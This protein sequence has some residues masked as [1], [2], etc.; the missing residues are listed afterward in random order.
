MPLKIS[1][2][3]AGR[4]TV[5]AT[6]SPGRLG[7]KGRKPVVIATGS[8]TAKAPGVVSIRLRLN[9][10]ARKYRKRLRGAT[11]VLLITQNGR[12]TTKAIRLR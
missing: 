5:T 6:V 8:A 1:V 9:T 2:P 10:K 7:L 12:T 3:A 11:V 4:V